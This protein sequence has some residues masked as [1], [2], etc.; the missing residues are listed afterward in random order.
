MPENTWQKGPDVTDKTV[1]LVGGGHTHALVLVALRAKPLSGARVVLVNPGPVAPYSGMLPGFVAGHYSRDALEID[2][3][4]LCE[5][6]GVERVDGAAVSLDPHARELRL[7]DGQALS[8]DV[9]SFDVG[10]TTQMPGLE[11]FA[12]NAVPAKPLGTFAARWA[13][14]RPRSVAVIGG[15]VAG[16][17]LV[18]AMAHAR[19]IAGDGDAEFHLLDRSAIL[20]EVPA[21]VRSRLQTALMRNKVSCH[22]DTAIASVSSSGIILQDGSMI[23]ADFVVGAAGAMPH[24][25]LAD[26]GLALY[27]GS[28]R[29]NAKLQASDNAVFAVGDCAHMDHAPRPKAG[30]YAVRQAPVLT[31]NLRAAV[32]GGPLQGYNPQD[33]YLKLISLGRKS[34]LGVYWGRPFSG[35]LVWRL[36]DWIDRRFMAQF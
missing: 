31:A 2:L 28:I 3:N 22:P 29:V 13:Q 35:P 15:G 20:S 10:I 26:T 18:M 9:I 16:A 36:K 25:W 4:A 24:P 17:E 23:E 6:S 21:P 32:S 33:D 30:V 1:V 5:S 27:E 8:Y 11:G 12:D 34:A 14:A 19:H 7:S